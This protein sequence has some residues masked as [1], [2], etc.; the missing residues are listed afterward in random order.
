MLKM[1]CCFVAR[2]SKGS[3]ME[4]YIVCVLLFKN[5]ASDL[6]FPWEWIQ[7]AV[8]CHCQFPTELFPSLKCSTFSCL[9]SV[10]SCYFFFPL[11]NFSYFL[12][13]FLKYIAIIPVIPQVQESNW[14]FF[15]LVCIHHQSFSGDSFPSDGEMADF[16]CPLKRCH[17]FLSSKRLSLKP[18]SHPCFSS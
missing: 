14:L 3:A 5:P 18:S 7:L 8:W 10:K 4:E 16:T 12:Q 9:C 1:W 2:F 6:P 15:A 17:L 11:G 13:V